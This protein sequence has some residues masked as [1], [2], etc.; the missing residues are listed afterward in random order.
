M[1]NR[2]FWFLVPCSG[3]V[4]F[5]NMF[6]ILFRFLVHCLIDYSGSAAQMRSR[7]IPI[8]KVVDSNPEL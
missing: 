3:F 5:Y 8:S 6:N 7:K 4:F 2:L 1:F